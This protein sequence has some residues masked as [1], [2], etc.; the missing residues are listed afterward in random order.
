MTG[1][2]ISSK[3][4]FFRAN[5]IEDG[6]KKKAILLSSCSSDI[7][8]L[9]KSLAAPTVLTSASYED[10]QHL[11]SEHKNPKPNSI[12]ELNCRIQ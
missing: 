1:I 4:I 9:F 12:T 6:N 5:G 7:Y 8:K 10:L 11:M 2:I 3:W